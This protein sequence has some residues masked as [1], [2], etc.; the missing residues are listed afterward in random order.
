[1]YDFITWNS[2]NTSVIQLY[3]IHNTAVQGNKYSFLYNDILK[4]I[5]WI[6]KLHKKKTD[7][8]ENINMNQLVPLSV[9]MQTKSFYTSFPE[10]PLLWNI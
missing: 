6:H 1:M 4:C 9:Y 3:N 2:Y 10:V 8:S 5:K 7:D